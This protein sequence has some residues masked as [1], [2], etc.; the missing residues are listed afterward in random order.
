MNKDPNI[1][2]EHMLQSI[3][4]IHEFVERFGRDG[5]FNDRAAS[6]AIVREFEV[7]GE[8]ATKLSTEFRAQHDTVPWREIV[9]M[10]NKLIHDYIAVDLD[11]VWSV[12]EQHLP[13]LEQALHDI[14]K[15]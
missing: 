15:S 11:T 1:Y 2:L 10:R 6:N 14:L 9:D 4:V 3:A 7:L 12:Y 5:F 13:A 8:A